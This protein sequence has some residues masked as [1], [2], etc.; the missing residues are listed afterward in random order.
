MSIVNVAVEG[1]TDMAV[2]SKILTSLGM[3][4]GTAYGQRGKAHLDACL[5]GFNT[6]ARHRPWLVVRDLDRDAGCAPE[7]RSTLLPK[8]SR[9]MRLRVATHAVESWLL[10]DADTLAR[11]L[12]IPSA[13]VPAEPDTVLDPKRRLVDLARL[14]RRRA[15]VDD[16]VPRPGSGRAVGPGYSARLSDFAQNHWRP[17]V[18]RT[19]S[20]SLGKCLDRL[21]E[22]KAFN[23]RRR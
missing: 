22:L 6:S 1:L 16:I 20:R 3:R 5:R 23:H 15:L 17:L 4:M 8:P 10:A 21:A 18:A 12:G 13:R 9:W 11:Y 2:V 7:L 14:S 19:N